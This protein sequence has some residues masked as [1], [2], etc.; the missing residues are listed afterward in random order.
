[1]KDSEMKTHI[2]ADQ[3]EFDTLL[4][5]TEQTED[6]LEDM[7]KDDKKALDKLASDVANRVIEKLAMEDDQFA[8]GESKLKKKQQ[9]NFSQQV[10]PADKPSI[11]ASPTKTTSTPGFLRPGAKR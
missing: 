3:K 10:K 2:K 8:P 4:N 1:M 7:K 6:K 11:P 9:Q 5:K